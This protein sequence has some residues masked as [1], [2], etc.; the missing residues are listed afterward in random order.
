MTKEQLNNDFEYA[1]DKLW[2]LYNLCYSDKSN[3]EFD[4]LHDDLL[5]QIE[6]LAQS[7]NEWEHD[8][9]NDALTQ[10][11]IDAYAYELKDV[12]EMIAQIQRH[13]QRVVV[14]KG[15]DGINWIYG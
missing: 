2:D 6:G 1:N 13:Y 11:D 5:W 15:E 10:K 3:D 7:F 14:D 12:R 9:D 4:E 8:R